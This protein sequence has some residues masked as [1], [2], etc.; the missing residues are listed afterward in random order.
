MFAP[1]AAGY[2]A[3]TDGEAVSRRRA[4]GG[5]TA[6]VQTLDPSEGGR[7]LSYDQETRTGKTAKS[8]QS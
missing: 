3:L 7:C 4:P 1:S 2:R 6:T 8:D 5:M